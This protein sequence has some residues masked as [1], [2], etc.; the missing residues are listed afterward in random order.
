MGK[1][2]IR[3]RCYR[4]PVQA[5]RNNHVSA[6]AV[7]S[8]N[9]GIPVGFCIIVISRCV[10]RLCGN[11]GKR[12]LGYIRQSFFRP[13]YRYYVFLRYSI[14]SF[15]GMGNAHFEFVYPNGHRK[16]ACA[17]NRVSGSLGFCCYCDFIGVERRV[18]RVA[19]CAGSKHLQQI[20]LFALYREAFKQRRPGFRGLALCKRC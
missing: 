10:H 5:I 4:V 7:I 3:Y 2:V 17:F 9:S 13:V 6:V 18:D 19:E 15:R 14:G 12:S 16:F 11:A 20:R 8:G 1:G